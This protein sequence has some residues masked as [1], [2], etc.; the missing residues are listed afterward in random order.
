M[1]VLRV[2]DVVYLARDGVTVNVDGWTYALA[3]LYRETSPEEWAPQLD[4]LDDWQADTYEID[5]TAA[6]RIADTYNTSKPWE[7]DG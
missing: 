2:R 1:A 3:D 4:A 7:Q 6:Q 5:R